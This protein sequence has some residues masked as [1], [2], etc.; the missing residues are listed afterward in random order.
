VLNFHNYPNANHDAWDAYDKDKMD[1]SDPASFNELVGARDAIDKVT[2]MVNFWVAK[3]PY[4]NGPKDL[5]EKE[6]FAVDH[7]ATPSDRTS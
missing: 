3:T 5:V 2:K 6:I 7:S 4:N 1:I